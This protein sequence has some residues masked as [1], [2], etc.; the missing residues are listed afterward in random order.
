MSGFLSF[1]HFFTVQLPDLAEN[2][3]SDVLFL[4]DNVIKTGRE[5]ALPGGA[6]NA[7]VGLSYPE[8][9]EDM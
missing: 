9:W 4:L 8:R 2:E 7:V 3:T 1:Q 5:T 6:H